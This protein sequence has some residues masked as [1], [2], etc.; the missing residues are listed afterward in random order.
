MKSLKLL[1]EINKYLATTQKYPENSS[2]KSNFPFN[3]VQLRKTRELNNEH[4]HAENDTKHR[5]KRCWGT[6]TTTSTERYRDV[7]FENRPKKG[8]P[9]E[10]FSKTNKYFGTTQNPAAPNRKRRFINKDL[11]YESESTENDEEEVLRKIKFTDE[12][13]KYMR[14]QN[15]VNTILKIKHSFREVKGEN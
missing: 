8:D 9:M 2:K 1:E 12:F 11:D 7:Q 15:I 5:Q 6:R 14:W 10:S 13:N 4:D 3:F